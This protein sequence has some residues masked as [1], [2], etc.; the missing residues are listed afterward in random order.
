MTNDIQIGK[1][2]QRK[3]K[4]T[5]SIASIQKTKKSSKGQKNEE[6][7]SM[8][9]DEKKTSKVEQQFGHLITIQSICDS[10]F[11][12]E[13][14]KFTQVCSTQTNDC[15]R[16]NDCHE[17][18]E[19]NKIPIPTI[20]QLRRINHNQ[21]TLRSHGQLKCDKKYSTKRSGVTGTHDHK[22]HGKRH[23]EKGKYAYNDTL[24]NNE[25]KDRHQRCWAGDN[26]GEALPDWMI[27][28][29]ERVRNTDYEQLLYDYSHSSTSES[30]GET[31]KKGNSIISRHS[32]NNSN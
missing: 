3:E 32:T 8:K 27:R 26:D 18:R 10:E 13:R 30:V 4:M 28:C 12:K 19:A 25:E 17:F 14:K 16:T 6:K 11:M 21:R 23:S 5:K 20:D 9:V 24:N 29:R 7:K 15:R 1:K 2:R 22:A 31:S